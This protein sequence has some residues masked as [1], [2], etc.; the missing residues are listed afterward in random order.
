MIHN[1]AIIPFLW[2]LLA[3]DMYRPTIYIHQPN[4]VK[5]LKY[6]LEDYIRCIAMGRG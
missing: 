3:G 4:M 2:M 1:L 6:I 5:R